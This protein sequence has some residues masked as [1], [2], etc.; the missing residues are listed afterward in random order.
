MWFYTPFT[1]YEYGWRPDSQA[2]VY[3]V[4]ESSPV[5]EL[6]EVGDHILSINDQPV[7]RT[8]LV[9]PLPLQSFYD[10]TIQRGTEI[11]DVTIPTSARPIALGIGHRLP[12]GIISLAGWLVGAMI[13]WFAQRD[14]TQAIGAGGIFLLAGV[15]IVGIQGAL[16]GIPG[17][18]FVGHP[19][20]FFLAVGWLYLG[21]IPR[22]EPLADRTRQ[23]FKWLLGLATVLA[24][25]AV[26]EGL[27]LFPRMTSFQEISGISIYSLGFLLTSLSL[28]T[29]VT[30]M[31]VR[32]F[33]MPDSSYQ[34][35]Q[36]RIVVI[37]M[38][39]GVLPAVLLTIIPRAL[40]DVVFLPFPL[41]ISL[42]GFIPAGYFYVIY[43]RGLLG[44]DIIF[45]QTAVFMVLALLM[46][47]VYGTGL[48]ILQNQFDFDNRAITPATLLF[49]PMLLFTLYT[50]RPI[51]H[52]IQGI[53]FGEVIHNQSI[54]LFASALSSN[55]ETATLQSMVEHVAGDL[56]ARQAVLVLKNRLGR[57]T[58]MAQIR[59]V[60]SKQIQHL[61]GFS[62]PL[63]RSVHQESYPNP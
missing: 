13:L 21:M 20:V 7:Q 38:A 11:L 42:L 45:S 53:F 43:R 27:F 52:K 9:Y 35:Q 3:T 28:L 32:A 41:A 24:M 49:L 48:F 37:F 18:W 60:I 33:R 50:S 61:E 51:Q 16:F 23:I 12:T 25:M 56:Q 29:A 4:L 19:L 31:A 46:L 5:V 17:T 34:R 26:F 63:L 39:I 44:L 55:P 58:P 30:I 15:T 54:P 59:V 62:Q 14:N 10:L 57:L 22:S 8:K 47:L 40:F 2:I 1:F 6:L 36:A